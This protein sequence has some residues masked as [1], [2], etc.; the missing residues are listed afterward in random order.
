MKLLFKLSLL[1]VVAFGLTACMGTKNMDKAGMK[2]DPN[3][4]L[5][6]KQNKHSHAKWM[7]EKK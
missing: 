7:M 6:K 3:F 2:E 1:T 5:M 4:M